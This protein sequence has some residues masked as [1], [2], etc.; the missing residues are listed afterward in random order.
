MQARVV[1]E[2][3]ERAESTVA[4]VAQSPERPQ[5]PSR[6]IRPAAA[7]A[8]V[9]GMSVFDMQEACETRS[10]DG[11]SNSGCTG[12]LSTL[13]HSQLADAQGGSS[14][15]S[16]PGLKLLCDHAYGL[17]APGAAKAS[18]LGLG[19]ASNAAKG[20]CSPMF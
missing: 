16:W 15:A 19:P 13:T 6:N 3:T 14:Q 2:L 4:T 1:L 5:R 17:A 20:N 7:P 8:D 12:Q 18:S 10:L 9:T 11:F